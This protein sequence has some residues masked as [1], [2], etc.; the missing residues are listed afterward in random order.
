[1]LKLSAAASEAAA[2]AA[3]KVAREWFTGINLSV[4]AG[5]AGVRRCSDTRFTTARKSV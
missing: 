5:M 3:A 1:M 2:A 4:T